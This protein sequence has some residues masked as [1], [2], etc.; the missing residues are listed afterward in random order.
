[1]RLPFAKA[2]LVVAAGLLVGCGSS[3][4]SRSASPLLHGN[5]GSSNLAADL[6][7]G[8]RLAHRFAS[9]YARSAYRRRPPRLPGATGA[10]T[11]QLAQAAGRVPPSRRTLR[12]RAVAIDLAR[13][14]PTALRGSVEIAD[15]RNPSFTVGFT[16]RKGAAGWRVVSASPPG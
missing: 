2:L 15:A 13:L 11:A 14:G 10:L 6:A 12:P 5:K 16:L 3:Q 4:E 9:S 1:M 8:A 7:P